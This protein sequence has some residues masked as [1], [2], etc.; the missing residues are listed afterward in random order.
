MAYL[1][2]LASQ[3]NA[4][5]AMPSCPPSKIVMR[6]LFDCLRTSFSPEWDH[7]DSTRQASIEVEDRFIESAYPAF[8]RAKTGH[9]YLAHGQ[10][11]RDLHR[12]RIAGTSVAQRD[13]RTGLTSTR[14]RQKGTAPVRLALPLGLSW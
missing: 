3:S 5:A 14:A 2:C 11:S 4:A 9:D 6:T 12:R 13:R 8:G 1:C 7:P 10:T